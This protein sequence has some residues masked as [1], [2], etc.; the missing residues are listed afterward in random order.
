MDLMFQIQNQ[1][2][3]NWKRRVGDNSKYPYDKTSE[4]IFNLLPMNVHNA[5]LK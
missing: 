4:D 5:D 1:I 2:L 3:L